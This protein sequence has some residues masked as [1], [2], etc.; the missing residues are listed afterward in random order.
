MSKLLFNEQ[1]LV[2]DKQLATLI[3]LN[4]AMVLQQIHYWV[5]INKK[6]DKNFHEGKYWTYNS[7]EDWHKEF[8]FWSEST[9]K[10]ILAKLR[11]SNLLITGNFNKQRR[12]RTLWY[13]INYEI[14][15]KIA[16]EAEG[17]KEEKVEADTEEKDGSEIEAKSE[18]NKAPKK[19][20]KMKGIQKVKMTQCKRSKWS[21]AKGQNDPMDQVKMTQPLPEINTEITT[22]NNNNITRVQNNVVVNDRELKNLKEKIEEVTQSSV[23]EENLKNYLKRP[24]G[25]YE[26]E[27]AIENYPAIAKSILKTKDVPNPVGLLFYIAKNNVKP[28]NYQKAIGIFK[29]DNFGSFEQH[30][31]E[32]GELDFLFEDLENI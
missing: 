12:D 1:P 25:Q 4:E 6:A 26:I 19:R 7:I 17:G 31:Y 23:I 14:L 16:E 22:E 13:T 5:E 10:R 30:H 21:N 18:I 15:E 3:G 28:P 24:N 11:K 2:I 29:R 8:P 32:D 27:T 9:V 20:K